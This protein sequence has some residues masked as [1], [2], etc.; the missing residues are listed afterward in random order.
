M[1]IL[2]LSFRWWEIASLAS[3][4]PILAFISCMLVPESPVFLVKKGRLDEAECNVSR[5]FGPQYDSKVEVKMISDNLEC[6][7]QSTTKKGDYVRNVKN[8]PER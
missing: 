1:Y 3:V 5:A 6:L 2:A 4:V 8:H 7:R